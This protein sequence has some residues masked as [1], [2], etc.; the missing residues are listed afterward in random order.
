MQQQHKHLLPDDL[1]LL[2]T[3]LILIH[4]LIP[5]TVSELRGNV[6]FQRHMRLGRLYVTDYLGVVTVTFYS[7]LH[8]GD[9]IIWKYNFAPHF[10][11]PGCLHY[12]EKKHGW[13]CFTARTRGRYLGPR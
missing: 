13:G 8:S 1:C 5:A 12:R 3:M 4:R 9:Q 2:R 6:K 11:G 7:F 10:A